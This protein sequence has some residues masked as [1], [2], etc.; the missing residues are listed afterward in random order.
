MDKEAQSLSILGT[1]STS[2]I[3][4]TIRTLHQQQETGL[5]LK[6]TEGYRAANGDEKAFAAAFDDHE[7]NGGD[8]AGFYRSGEYSA[9]SGTL[10][11]ER[12]F[13]IVERPLDFMHRCK[14]ETEESYEATPLLGSSSCRYPIED[15]DVEQIPWESRFL[16]F[17]S[18]R[19]ENYVGLEQELDP[20]SA[21]I[22]SI[23][24]QYHTTGW[25]SIISSSVEDARSQGNREIKTWTTTPTIEQTRLGYFCRCM[26]AEHHSSADK[27]SSGP[28]DEP[29]PRVIGY[30]HSLGAILFEDLIDASFE[31]RFGHLLVCDDWIGWSSQRSAHEQSDFMAPRP[32]GLPAGLS[33]PG[34]RGTQTARRLRICSKLECQSSQ[35]TGIM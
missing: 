5:P 1:S 11:I 2:P 23:E 16:A 6:I 9:Q 13:L 7:V 19:I 33:I 18:C 14:D 3:P 20:V 22:L 28:T 21:R 17:A 4:Q 12:N 34:S 27:Q 31:E 25:I 10:K 8:S 26:C 24:G 29:S 15:P 35:A 32:A 30:F